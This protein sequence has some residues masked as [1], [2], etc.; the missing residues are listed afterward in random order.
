MSPDAPI[1]FGTS[2]WRGVLGDEITA[3]RV[4]ALAA[5]VASWARDEI[6]ARPRIVVAHDTRFLGS[7]LTSAAAA[8]LAAHGADA[9]LV[10]SP[11]PTP[12]V[13]HA[14]RRGQADAAWITTA[15]HNRPADQGVKVFAP[16]GGG[17]DRAQAARIEG[18]AR[19][20]LGRSEPPAP[21]LAAG[22]ALDLSTPYRDALLARIEPR[23]AR[24]T[25][26]YDALHGAGAGVCDRVLAAL[27]RT[28][29]LHHG[30]AR[31][32]FGGAA[33]DPTPVRLAAL[34][35][36]IRAARGL[37]L[38]LA[39]D[40]DADRFAVLDE[41]GRALTE[42][43]SL[44]LLV[45]HVARTGRARRGLAISIAT[46]SL[47]EAVARSYG[48]AVERHPIGFKHLSRALAEGSA[49]VAGEESGGF[50]WD[51]IGRD[52][53]GILA[54][55]LFVEMAAHDGVGPRARLRALTQRYG[56]SVCGR[57][58]YPA[59]RAA[60]DRLAALAAAPPS[61]V[62]S[63]RV[64]AV[65]LRDGVRLGFDDGFV[66]LR[67]SGTESLLRVYAEAEDATALA[68][69]FAAGADLL[70]VR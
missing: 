14:V 33:P 68:R 39:T 1:R 58:A 63:A 17:V 43:E 21:P 51:P 37:R 64:A 50:A 30:T 2:G 26:H 60:R 53:D 42:T 46:G 38:G 18:L 32:R 41:H 12:V 16:S 35:R 7:E 55:A 56:P 54:C 8:T 3:P 59:T 15:S 13:A 36:A 11:V 52:K 29:A 31:P 66:M 27:A 47:V 48:L 62:G 70:G 22:P 4:R 24:V 25:V 69:R 10:A 19:E 49:D 9:R 28:V 61:R 45:D 20:A 6:C 67:A 5:A 44:A 65:D 23:R 40:G 34:G 57:V